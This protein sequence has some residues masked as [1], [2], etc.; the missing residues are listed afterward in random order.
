MCPPVGFSFL[1]FLYSLYST[2]LSFSL[3]YYTLRLFDAVNPAAASFPLVAPAE[4]GFPGRFLP[5]NICRA[6]IFSTETSNVKIP[7]FDFIFHFRA[8][9]SG[10]VFF[11]PFQSV[12]IRG[13]SGR[14]VPDNS[15][16]Q[17][18]ASK[19]A[20]ANAGGVMAR[21]S[22]SVCGVTNCSCGISAWA[23]LWRYAKFGFP[24]PGLV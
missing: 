15:E 11:I 14:K 4:T 13:F 1:G 2:L 3:L 22:A 5:G 17:L 6:V 7:L 12:C 9:F 21:N 10:G 24:L 19:N 16:L 8:P 20:F 23:D 18:F